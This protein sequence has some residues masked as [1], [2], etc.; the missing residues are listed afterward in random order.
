[1]A[2]LA[3]CGVLGAC[4][5]NLLSTGDPL[6]PAPD[7]IIVAHQDDDLIFMQP[8]LLE[9][10]Q[11]GDG[12]T[13]VY[14]TAGSNTAGTAQADPRY[15]GLMNAYGSA[16]GSQ[17]WRC[18]W[19]D[20][21]GH[22]AEHCRLDEKRIS[23]V[24]LGYPDGGKV[25]EYEASL[26]HLWEGT[27]TTVETVAHRKAYYDRAG[28]IDVVADIVRE[29]Q[30][31]IVRTLEV[32]A[33]HG[34][35]HSDHMLVGALAMLAIARANSQADVL[36]YRAYS[37]ADE[38]PNKS[39]AIFD[40]TYAMLGYYEACAGGCG[41]CGEPCTDIGEV[42]VTWLRRRYAIGFRHAS[43]KLRA[44]T[45]CLTP[46]LTFA[47]CESAL[48]WQLDAYGELRAA[49]GGCLEVS[50]FG[51]LAMTACLGGRNRRF[52]FDDEGHLWSG[53]PPRAEAN[54]DYAHLWCLA[55]TETGVRVQMC[56]QDRAPTWE[57]VPRT[58]ETARADM[59]IT[60]TGREVRIGDLT[61]D[62]WG[63][64]CAIEGG[65]VCAPG[66]G[67]GG[68]TAAARID[69]DVAPLAIDPR[70]LT[71]GD[72]DGD[73]RADAC[74]RDAEGV[75]CALAANNFAAERFSPSFNE[76]LAAASTSAS[77]TA[78]DANADGV[79]D[80]CGI[81]QTGVVC[82]PRGLSLQP[83]VRS[84]WPSP[85]DVLWPADL[86]G[87]HQ[88]DWCT[89]TDTGPACAV[90]AQRELSTD[91]APWAYSQAGIVEVAPATTATVALADVDG[92]GRADLCSLHED[93][94]L[95][96]RSQGR[97]FGPRGTFAILPNQ[98]VASALWL[99]DLDGD[100]RAD[101]CADTGATI[102]CAIR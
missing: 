21:D 52:F 55:P 37:A 24:F 28:L 71:L 48:S 38:P 62:G 68:F 79:A 94:I 17:A 3:I 76:A 66:D 6:A 50:D 82:A 18:G 73:G 90:E 44:G 45:Q 81:E 92:D 25:G 78:V 23:L 51:E 87:D 22:T 65:L 49:D 29:T 60:A 19:I 98:S 61:G 16:A 86:D 97:A 54:L 72:V 63:D 27:V 88:A 95:C 14:V 101:A 40:L 31:R 7:L 8:D 35:D 67:A 58:I 10:V 96:A 75:L 42:H 41:T 74:G 59:L 56:G 43:G 9:A 20:I 84:Q 89:A 2:L 13:S 77:L 46:Q 11:R 26:L 4:G 85:T 15:Q 70:S 83:I 12:V 100:G 33:T 64:L 36:A 47:P 102:T 57:L 99:G 53:T 69:S 93:R 34:R 91:G 39:E 30:P 32:A 80:I 5:D 1:V